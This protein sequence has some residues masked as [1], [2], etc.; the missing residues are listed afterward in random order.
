MPLNGFGRKEMV[1]EEGEA[2]ERLNIL[3]SLSLSLSLFSYY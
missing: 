1:E 3:L 2:T